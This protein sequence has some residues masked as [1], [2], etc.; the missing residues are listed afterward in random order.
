ME[1]GLLLLIQWLCFFVAIFCF[2]VDGHSRGYNRRVR[3][4]RREAY[5]RA[6]AAAVREAIKRIDRNQ[7]RRGV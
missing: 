6:K 4:A 2:W 7:P 5:E 1:S 3:D